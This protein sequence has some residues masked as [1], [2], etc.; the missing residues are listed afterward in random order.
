MNIQQPWNI[1]FFVGFL[2]FYWTR[3]VYINRTKGEKKTISHMDRQEKLLLFAMAPTTLLLPLLYLFTPFLSFADY[4][5]PE[6]LQALGAALMA[7]SLWLFWRSHADLGKNWSV[8]LEIREGHELVTEGVYRYV[9]HPMYTAIWLWCIGQG[10]LLENWAAGWAIIPTFAAMYFL[11]ANREEQMMCET[12]GDQYRD[13][14]Q[15]TGR[16]LPRLA[17]SRKEHSEPVTDDTPPS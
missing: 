11:R 6:I 5:L 13:Y 14:M 2:I 4:R 9:R 15:R 12:F 8:S 16:L 3:H 7:L 10:L 1:V 17:S